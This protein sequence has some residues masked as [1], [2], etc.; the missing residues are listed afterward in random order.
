M[1]LA[2]EFRWYERAA[3]FLPSAFVGYYSQD[4]IPGLPAELSAYLGGLLCATLSAGAIRTAKTVN[5]LD[6]W[7]KGR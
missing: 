1:V 3:M 6:W 7:K 2:A 4:L 5:L